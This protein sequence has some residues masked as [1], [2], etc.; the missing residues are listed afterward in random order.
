MEVI[1]PWAILALMWQGTFFCALA[2]SYT[3]IRG[4]FYAS[5][6]VMSAL[7]IVV[8]RIKVGLFDSIVA[9]Q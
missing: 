1:V 8:E 4:H 6:T 9:Q 3:M 7:P 5:L 2:R